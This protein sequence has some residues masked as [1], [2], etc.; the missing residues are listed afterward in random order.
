MIVSHTTCILK[1]LTC[2]SATSLFYS[3][4]YRNATDL[5]MCILQPLQCS[6]ISDISLTI[7]ATEPS[8]CCLSLSAN[9]LCKV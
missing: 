2:A 4:T 3:S 7:S 1:Q 5:M 9:Q 6:F 8:L